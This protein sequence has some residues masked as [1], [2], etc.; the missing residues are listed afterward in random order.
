MQTE[1]LR[2]LSSSTLVGVYIYSKSG[3]VEFA[4][5]TFASMLGYK[6]EEL[7]GTSLLT[8]AS[9]HE[10]ML[11]DNLLRKKAN[12]EDFA[13]DRHANTYR[14]HDGSPVHVKLFGQTISYNGENAVLVLV[15]DARKEKSFERLFYALSQVTRLVIHASSQQ[16]MFEEICDLLVDDIGYAS[17][18]IGRIENGHF[19]VFYVKSR[20]KGVEALLK[21]LTI[22]SDGTLPYGRGTVFRACQSGNVTII[23]DVLSHKDMSAWWEYHRHYG[24]YSACSI[25]IDRNGKV[26]YVLL[27]HDDTKGSFSMQHVHLLKQIQSSIA[28][29]LRRLEAERFIRMFGSAIDLAHELVVLLDDD[30]RVVYVNEAVSELFGYPKERLIGKDVFRFAD[31]TKGEGLHE[32]LKGDNERKTIACRTKSGRTLYLDATV[33]RLTGEDENYRIILAR[34]VTDAYNKSLQLAFT[35]RIYNT[36]YQINHLYISLKNKDEIIKRLPRIF[37]EYMGIDISFIVNLQ[38]GKIH[39]ESSAVSS[40]ELGGFA[41][42]LTE[43][44]SSKKNLTFFEKT[45]IYKAYTRNS[46]YIVN[47]IN[48]R[49]IGPLGEVARSYGIYSGCAIPITGG[50]KRRVLVLASRQSGVFKKEVYFLLKNIRE[51]LTF[52]LDKISSNRFS[53]LAF[54]AMDSSFDFIFITDSNF[55]IVWSNQSAKHFFGF[56]QKS[57]DDVNFLELLADEH[58]KRQVISSMDLL[59]NHGNTSTLLRYSVSGGKVAVAPTVITRVEVEE[60]LVYHIISGKNISNEVRLQEQISRLTMFDETT[61][62]QNRK[63]F[64]RKLRG[65]I[66]TLRAQKESGIVGCVAVINPLEFRQVNRALGYENGNLV[67]AMIASRIKGALRD[68][69]EVARLESDKFGVLLKGLKSEEDALIVL[70]KVMNELKRPYVV[71]DQHIDISFAAGLSLIPKDGTDPNKLINR[72]HAALTDAKSRGENTS[73]FFRKEVEINAFEKLRLK[74]EMNRAIRRDEFVLFYQPYF[75]ANGGIVGAEALLRWRT[76]DGFVSPAAFVPYLEETGAIVSVERIVLKK[77]LSYLKSLEEKR[78]VIVPVSL[79]VSPEHLKKG[80]FMDVFT[81]RVKQSGVNPSYVN[82]EIVERSFLDDIEQARRLID[83]IKNF[84]FRFLIDDFGTGYSSLSY[85][86]RLNVDYVKIDISFVRKIPD[87]ERV[88]SVVRTIVNLAHDLGMRCIAEGVETTRQFDALVEMGCDYFQGYL[89]ARPLPQD[90]FEKILIRP[91][92]QVE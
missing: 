34:D 53:T 90:E 62:L 33:A 83:S 32:L 61:H 48:R 23:S 12:N 40:E 29:A 21:T 41:E 50:K 67:L 57:L 39:V 82:I 60:D 13:Y 36:L 92:R 18:C 10:K 37:V 11:L 3:R 35:T 74:K 88:V 58:S 55:R 76:T 20:L 2:E 63:L 9:E 84:G 75:D 79:N 77:V 69:D 16:S 30:N 78:A 24:I 4:N 22:K 51:S 1:F 47:D 28:Y 5:R 59:G 7:V 81:G 68:Y 89:F 70:E 52:I 19:R 8:F 72:A 64:V 26:A 54:S 25:P 71:G 31:P 73:A 14:A 27:I 17:A 80:D 86:S 91:D 66:S 49:S 46:I 87:D 15:F 6:P 56:D 43:V 45:P 44:S 42:R 65:F 85:L 38:G